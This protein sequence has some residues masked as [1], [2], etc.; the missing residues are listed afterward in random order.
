MGTSAHI[1]RFVLDHLPP[2]DQQPELIFDLPE[3]NYP[4]RLNAG[5]ELLLHGPN[6]AWTVLAGSRS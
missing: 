3:L 1:D 6:S 4:E 5:V 2:A